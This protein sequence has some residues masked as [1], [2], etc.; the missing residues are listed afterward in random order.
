MTKTSE[1]PIELRSLLI[2][3]AK[4]VVDN[5]ITVQQANA[6][7]ALSAEVH[8]SLKMQYVGQ[9]IHDGS[10]SIKEGRLLESIGGK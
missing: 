4:A 6:V 7:S 1:D 3:C 2:E 10:F 5:R 9:I 8:K